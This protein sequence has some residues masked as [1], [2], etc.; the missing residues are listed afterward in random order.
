MS[1][2]DQQSLEQAAIVAHQIRSPVGTLQTL[3]QTLLGGF[4]GE[5][6]GP[7]KKILQSADRRCSEAMETI[8]GLLALAD[9]SGR[10]SDEA[11]ADLVAAANETR[12][13]Y[14]QVAADKQIELALGLDAGEAYV[15]ADAATLTEAVAA[16]VENA[17]K[18]T[19]E[20]GRVRVH[21]GRGPDNVLL[22]IE[23]SGIGIP[24][25]ERE[26]LFQ[27]FFRA[28]NA[29][30]LMPT[31][32]GLGLA[33]ARA[34]FKAAGGSIT[35]ERSELGGTRFTVALPAVRK[36]EGLTAVAKAKRREPSFRAVVIGGVAA[37]PKIASK[38]MRLQP[39]AEVTIVEMG[40]VLSYAGCGLPY[41][42]SGLVKNQRELVSTPEGVVRGPEYFERVKNV[43]VMNR[44]EALKIA[45]AEHRVLV[46]DLI[47]GEQ[48]WLPYDKLAITTGAVPIIPSVPGIHLENIFT[49]HGLEHAEGIR[50]NLAQG[51]AK[52]VVIVGGGLIGVEMAE[53]LVSAGCRVTLLEMLPQLLP[54]VL[55]PEMAELVRQ[56]FEAKGVRVLLGTRASGFEGDGRVRRVLTDSEAIPADMAIMG[57]GV[58]PNVKLALEAGLDIG[59]TGAVLVDEYMRTSDPDIYAAGDC[60]QCVDL[61]TG[62]PCY[63]PLGSTANK[64]GR[65][66]ALNICGRDDRFPG[67][68]GTTVCRVFDYTVARAGLTERQARLAGY[69]CVTTITAGPDRAHF[70]PHAAMLILKLVAD[71]RTRR[72]LGIQALG[73]GEAAKRVDVA[74][75]AI[76]GGLTVDQVA[77][78]D[79]CYAPSYSDALDNLHT[80]CNVMKN[81][82]AGDLVGISPGEVR[83]KLDAGEDVVLLDVRTHAEFEQAQLDGSTHIPVGALRGR[84]DKL[85]QDKEIITF[86]RVSLSA[87]EAAIILKGQGF[88]NV[89]VMDGGMVM[90]PSAPLPGDHRRA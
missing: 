71:A 73:P 28:S 30:K 85:P 2:A 62:R 33:F 86:S 19:P 3:I 49:L 68:V 5:V 82:L 50:A 44:T 24:D 21:V 39:D 74:V 17:V 11:A 32:T 4:A 69:E 1:D 90:W 54:T 66:A 6:T 64:Q 9:A 65:V 34:V 26:R 77:N 80:A 75:T 20:Q 43:R 84:L 45:R 72:L 79:L 10:T 7:Q 63:S 46:R 15:G 18:Y 67:V 59:E 51:R 87:Y 12:E 22:T 53:S 76:T 60:V 14:R 31:G 70:M 81:K 47:S 52:D 83:R 89:K 25:E 88:Q 56:Q 41:Y 57:V 38:I 29:R 23:D 16:L 61:V 13:R 78:L 36:P 48:S 40:R 35:A 27:P 42:I 37:G 8:R 58:R 55:D